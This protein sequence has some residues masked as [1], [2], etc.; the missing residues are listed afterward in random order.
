MSAATGWRLLAAADV[1]ARGDAVGHVPVRDDRAAPVFEF[2]QLTQQRRVVF[3]RGVAC[4]D[5]GLYALDYPGGMGP[6][7]RV[8]GAGSDDQCPALAP[9]RNPAYPWMGGRGYGHA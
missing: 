7:Q 8:C 9:L 6:P 5:C 1:Q 2:G 3:C 4:R